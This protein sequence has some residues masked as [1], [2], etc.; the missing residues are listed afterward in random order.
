[1]SNFKKNLKDNIISP[2][3]KYNLSQEKL[4]EVLSVNKKKKTCTV[5]Y[6]NIDGIKVITDNVPVKSYLAYKA[7]GFP[8][9]GDYVEIQEVGKTIRI[10]NV[11]DKNLATGENQKTEDEY[12]Y[13]CDIG[14]YLGI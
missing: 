11:L 12:S 14:G 2:Y 8:K 6:R 10:T 9:K 5:S 1:M 4:G 7:G 13:S 3:N